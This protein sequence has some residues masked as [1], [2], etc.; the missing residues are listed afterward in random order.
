LSA[1]GGLDLLTGALDGRLVLSGASEQGGSRP[2]IFVALK[3]PLAAPE[4]TIDASALT[5][6]LTLRAIENESKKIRAIEQAP[7]RA[8]L[9]RP[10]S[11][12]V[13][14]KRAAPPEVS[15]VGTQR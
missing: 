15:A 12:A 11:E 9:P 10:K 5:G 3:G 14:P 6:W 1:T 7:P 13:P 2:D 8:P 4:R